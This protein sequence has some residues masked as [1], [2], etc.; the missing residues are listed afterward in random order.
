LSCIFFIDD[1]LVINEPLCRIPRDIDLI[2]PTKSA[3]ISSDP[4]KVDKLLS[5]QIEEVASEHLKPPSPEG[6]QSPVG[7]K[8]ASASPTLAAPSHDVVNSSPRPEAIELPEESPSSP[9]SHGLGAPS[10][11]RPDEGSSVPQSGRQP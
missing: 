8:G 9:R 7:A 6:A 10:G 11:P 1:Y 3:P 5:P 4:S 2:S